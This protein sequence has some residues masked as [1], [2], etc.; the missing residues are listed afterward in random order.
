MN[1]SYKLNSESSIPLYKQIVK[2]ISDNVEQGIL[3]SGTKLPSEFEL[4]TIFGVSR[5][6]IRAAIDELENMGIVKRSRGKGTFVTAQNIQPKTGREKPSFV[7]AEMADYSSERRVGFTHSCKLAG[8]IA[9]TNVLDI[10][11]MYPNVLDM[12]FFKIEEDEQIIAST[13]LRYIDGIP[14]TIEKNHYKKQFEYLF[15]EIK[16][17]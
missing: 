15:Y 14:T 3:K 11:W 10:S 17:V 8:K 5:I 1:K 2:I 13:R 6:T 16:L 4:I 9:T 12:D 7:T